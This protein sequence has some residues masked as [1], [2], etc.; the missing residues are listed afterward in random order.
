MQLQEDKTKMEKELLEVYNGELLQCYSL[1]L[2]I[3]NPD[4]RVFM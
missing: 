3:R 4:K 1:Q 2:Y